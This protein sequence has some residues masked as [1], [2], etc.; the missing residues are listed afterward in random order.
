MGN[1]IVLGVVAGAVSFLAGAV[2]SQVTRGDLNLIPSL[3]GGVA[4]GVVFGAL[5]Q[6]QNN[7]K[8]TPESDDSQ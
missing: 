8:S 6:W 1:P 7:K 5:M 3:V 4:F 2:T